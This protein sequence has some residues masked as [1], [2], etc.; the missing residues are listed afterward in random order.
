MTY[1]S[2]FTSLGVAL[3]IAKL[4]SKHVALNYFVLFTLYFMFA[5]SILFAI[6]T[7]ELKSTVVENLFFGHTPFQILF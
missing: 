7:L 3:Y 5:K 1:T 2:L 4:L 6:L